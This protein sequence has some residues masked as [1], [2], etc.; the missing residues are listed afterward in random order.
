MERDMVNNPPHYGKG[1]IECIEYIQDHLSD[2]EYIGY[3]RGNIA[4]YNHRWR[5]K[6]GL[7]DL[8]KA[9]WYHTRLIEFVEK[10]GHDVDC[11]SPSM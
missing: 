8:K 5:Y 2:E 4:K 9:N 6:H 10:G 7:E 3:L 1:H 11:T